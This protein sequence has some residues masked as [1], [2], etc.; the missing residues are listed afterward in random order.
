MFARNSSV[1]RFLWVAFQIDS[2]CAQNTDHDIHNS[3]RDLPEGLPATFRRILRRLQHSAF[4][5]PSL[6]TKIFEIVAAA[7]RPLTLNELGEAISITPGETAWNKS[8][9][10]NDVLKSLESC[11][12]FIVVDEELSTVHFAHSSVKRHLL[13]EPTE[14]DVR[15]YHVDPSQA[16]INLGRIAVTYLSLNVLDNQLIKTSGPPQPYAEE[17]PSFVAKSALPKHEVI[18]RIALAILR[19]RKTP[20]NDSGVALERSANLLREQDTQTQELF[21]FLSY[22]Q[23]YWL[24]H[25][26][27]IHISG[28]DRVYELWERLVNGTVRTVELP[29]APEKQDD[30][31][32]QFMGWIVKNHHAALLNKAVQQLWFNLSA[33][34]SISALYSSVGFGIER[35]EQLL[36]LLQKGDVRLSFR[37]NPSQRYLPVEASLDTLLQVAAKWGCEAIVRLALQEGAYVNAQNEMYGNALHE[38]VSSGKTMIAELL[39]REGADVNLQGGKYGSA[40]QAGAAT[41]GMDPIVK[42]LIE[43]GADVNTDSGEYGTALIAAASIGNE[44]AIRLLLKAGAD[45]NADSGKYGTALIAAAANDNAAIIELLLE[46][47][48]VVNAYAL[49]N[50]DGY[51]RA[52]GGKHVTAL[53]AAVSNDNLLA[54]SALLEAGAD[55]DIGGGVNDSPLQVAARHGN[56]QVVERLIKRGPRLEILDSE[57][58]YMKVFGTN[59]ATARLLYAYR[60]NE[61]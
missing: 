1:F 20:G 37:L 6:G 28:H 49:F 32:G 16:N 41:C 59:R 26:K 42:L 45:I 55:V 19:G 5:D 51:V 25:T 12:S 57:R 46:S 29:W 15:D 40:L 9:L 24:H 35:L 18:N 22:C 44:A 3:L 17:L 48:A 31:G 11:G 58:E 39:I 52:Y 38:A 30:L 13:S 4:A 21:S 8:K 53:L 34:S 60:G 50:A 10:V 36:R 23:E 54:V 61:F 7:Q 56:E 2:I 14:L 43:N 47:G 27:A 33:I